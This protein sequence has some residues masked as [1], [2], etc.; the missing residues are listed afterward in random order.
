MRVPTSQR[1][2]TPANV[3]SCLGPNMTC[4]MHRPQAAPPR[5]PSCKP[6]AHSTLSPRH[7]CVRPCTVLAFGFASTHS[8]SRASV[9][10]QTWFFRTGALSCSL[11]AVTGTDVLR[12]GGHHNRTAPIGLPRSSA[13]APVTA[14]TIEHSPKPAGSFCGSGST[15]S[16]TPRPSGSGKSSAAGVR[17]RQDLQC[18]ELGPQ[19]L[20]WQRPRRHPLPQHRALPG[21]TSPGARR[22]AGAR[23][24]R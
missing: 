15:R 19:A 11:M 8:Q 4:C 22:C 13:T 23:S 5:E 21:L 16:P 20:R 7:D 1:Q 14:A 18:H 3:V 12:T 10:A 2:A 24:P 6:T 9:A 17:T